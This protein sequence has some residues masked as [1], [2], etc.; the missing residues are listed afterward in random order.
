MALPSF[1]SRG[2]ARKAIGRKL[3]LHHST[4][5][6]RLRQ[7]GESRLFAQRATMAQVTGQLTDRLTWIFP[8]LARGFSPSVEPTCKR[9]KASSRQKWCGITVATRPAEG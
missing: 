1:Q 7:I 4:L 2:G 9:P 6:C 5:R 3:H 8:P